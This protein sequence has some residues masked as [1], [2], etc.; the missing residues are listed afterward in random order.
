[1]RFQFRDEG[2]IISTHYHKEI[3]KS[4]NPELVEEKLNKVFGHYTLLEY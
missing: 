3:D 4:S 2:L 1:M